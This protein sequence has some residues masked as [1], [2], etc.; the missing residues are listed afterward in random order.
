MVTWEPSINATA[1]QV[2]VD[3]KVVGKTT[4]SSLSVANIYGPAHTVEVIP[5]G[6]DGTQGSAIATSIPVTEIA[7]GSL[8]FANNSAILS[9]TQKKLLDKLA[10]TIKVSG[11]TTVRLN[12]IVQQIG[13]G[14][15]NQALAAARATAVKT[16]LQ[17]KVV[18]TAIQFVVSAN[19][20]VSAASKSVGTNRVDVVV[21]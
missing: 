8:N 1:Y 5:L 7:V 17:S 20:K 15:T 2:K 4:A 11:I 21:R 10:S 6:N 19:K 9:K 13:A 3:G 16:Y 14:T 12:G 18:N